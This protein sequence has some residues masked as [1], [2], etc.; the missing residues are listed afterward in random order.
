[1]PVDYS[2]FEE[3]PKPTTTTGVD[4]SLFPEIEPQTS[5]GAG[6]SFAVHPLGSPRGEANLPRTVAGGA[7]DLTEAVTTLPTDIIGAFGSEGAEQISSNIREFIPNLPPG[8]TYEEIGNQLVQYGIP[9]TTAIKVVNR[10][11]GGSKM[12]IRFV[13]DLFAGGLADF[14]AADVS[15]PTLGDLVGGPTQKIKGEKPLTTRMKI[16][17]EGVAIPA[18]VLPTSKLVIGAG[19]WVG[20]RVLPTAKMIE[21]ALAVTFHKQTLNPKQAIQNIQEGL[22]QFEG[23]GFRPTTGTLSQDESLIAFEKATSAQ[24]KFA[25]SSSRMMEREQVNMAHLS[26]E[27]GEVTK[28]MGGDPEEAKRFFFEYLGNVLEGKENAYQ[29]ANQTLKRVDD[30]AELMIKQLAD[31]TKV[32]PSVSALLDDTL[33]KE[34]RTVTYKRR[35]LYDAVDPNREVLI[36]NKRVKEAFNELTTKKGPLDATA[37]QVP[38]DLKSLI[39]KAVKGEKSKKIA[40]GFVQEPPKAP[41]IKKGLTYGDIQVD[42][43]PALSDAIATARAANQG[44]LVERLVKF[45]K[46]LDA[47]DIFLEMGGGEASQA[48]SKANTYHMDVYTPKFKQYVGDNY[49]RAIRR[50]KDIPPSDVA[51]KFLGASS[52]TDEAANQLRTILKDSPNQ[53][54]A[55]GAANKYIVGQ[56]AEQIHGVK[57]PSQAIKIIDKFLHTR[58]MSDTLAHFPDARKEILDY[59]NALTKH[60]ELST[61]MGQKVESAKQFLKFTEKEINLNSAKWFIDND[62]IRAMRSVIESANPEKAM[63]DLLQL[64]AKD[65]TGKAKEGLR[66]ALSKLIESPVRRGGVRGSREILHKDAFEITTSSMRNLLE[67]EPT[68]KAIQKLYTP[69]EMSVLKDIHG[70][71]TVMNRKNLQITSGSPTA[72]LEESVRSGQVLAFS[73]FGIVKGR[74]IFMVS[75]KVQQMLGH[76]PVEKAWALLTD[77]MLDP[78]LAA[79]LLMKASDTNLSNIKGKLAVYMLNNYPLSKDNEGNQP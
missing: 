10:V 47:E 34:L 58:K 70:K 28:R 17:A 66:V 74:G 77:A 54:V 1:M 16:G 71:L 21:N 68:R 60:K 9:S 29:L 2:L 49:R 38:G 79:T 52:G 61:T 57:N 32:T 48:I 46:A 15:E 31:Q 4:T 23:S 37:G 45:K 51:G 13:A 14:V 22:K 12:A 8:N 44:G 41:K 62:P 76:D 11:M 26:D 55:E 59:R 43:R 53:E 35:E 3:E 69:K 6:G 27:L 72:I 30:E 7:L 39:N 19:K 65:T 36:D 63:N 24:Q 25:Q 40:A 56:L 20:T 75:R 42:L 67:Y 18:A 78:D 33:K 64:A 5:S 73:L 50:G